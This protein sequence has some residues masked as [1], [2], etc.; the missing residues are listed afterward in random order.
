MLMIDQDLVNEIER[1]YDNLQ[2]DLESSQDQIREYVLDR[3]IPLEERWEKWTKLCD[4]EEHHWI[5]NEV[6]EPIL[7]KW[8][9]NND[10]WLE[11]RYRKFTWED[12]LE[13]VEDCP[14]EEDAWL[15][16]TNKLI[17][18]DFNSVDEFKEYLIERNFGSFINDW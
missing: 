7:G 12:Y 14:F 2:Q 15:T 1:R 16:T 9:R 5:I 4:K 3:D 8:F 17:M 18:S 13:A 11:Q 10:Y 6:E